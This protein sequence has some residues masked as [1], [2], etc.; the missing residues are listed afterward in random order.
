[1]KGRR[2][3]RRLNKRIGARIFFSAI[4]VACVVIG[5]VV[6]FYSKIHRLTTGGTWTSAVINPFAEDD[7]LEPIAHN[8]SE[9][10]E[11]FLSASSPEQLKRLCRKDDNSAAIV[12]DHASEVLSWLDGHRE[13]MPMHEAK[14]NGL[15]FTVFGLS[16]LTDRPRPVYVV[17]TTEGPKIDIGAFLVWS[18]ED[19]RDLAT[20]KATEAAIVRATATRKA[21][22][23]YNFDDESAYQSYR[24]DP[25]IEAPSLWGYALRGSATAATLDQLVGD[26]SSFP[27]VI[28]L[29][30]GEENSP[31]RQ[32]RISRVIAAGWA[33]GPQIIEEHLPKLID[34]PGLL[35]PINESLPSVNFDRR[36]GDR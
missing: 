24:L 10:V 32:F 22:Y 27:V 29:D 17:Q 14:A 18:S 7:G 20:G 12:D 11:M 26:G 4:L 13:W 28:S 16:H 9:M 3:R 8:P 25:H 31:T 34:D 30:R 5:V 36:P 2:E 19:W 23:N 35:T 21:Y 15:M 6:A 1:M 33:I